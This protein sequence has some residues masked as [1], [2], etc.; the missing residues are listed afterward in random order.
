[1][2]LD[3]T[4]LSLSSSVGSVLLEQ[5]L[6]IS[7]AES[8]T[9]GLLSHALTAQSGSSAYFMGGVVAYSN[10]IKERI[11]GVQPETLLVF[12]AVSLQTAG[13]MAQGV[14][15]K[16]ETDIGLSTTGIAGPTGGTPEKPV[17]LV[18]IGISTPS[19]TH[20]FENHF[21]GSRFEIMHQTVIEVLRRLLDAGIDQTKP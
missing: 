1:M 6:T 21:E 18:W 19:R 16:F 4:L 15:L 3:P 9:G 14:R 8:C 5:G 2:D 10:T 7:T 20:A 11:L 12:G 17:G 13:Q